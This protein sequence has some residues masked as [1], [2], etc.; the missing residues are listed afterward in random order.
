VRLVIIQ[1]IYAHTSPAMTA[2]YIGI[3]SEEVAAGYVTFERALS[4][5]A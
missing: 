5:V 1:G 4:V 2:Y 3:E